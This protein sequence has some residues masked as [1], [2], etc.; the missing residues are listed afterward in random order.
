MSFV[1]YGCSLVDISTA[2][3]DAGGSS[4]DYLFSQ[5]TGDLVAIVEWGAAPPFCLAG[6]PTLTLPVPSC[7]RAGDSIASHECLAPDGSTE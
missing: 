2:P 4:V 7:F 3:L 1:Q 5:Q 6:P